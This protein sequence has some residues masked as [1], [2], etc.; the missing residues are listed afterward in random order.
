[1]NEEIVAERIELG[2]ILKLDKESLQNL[3]TQEIDEF[4]RLVECGSVTIPELSQH[5]DRQVL[6]ICT[7]VKT[8]G[9]EA[10]GEYDS[11]ITHPLPDM[12][13]CINFSP[14]DP[15]PGDLLVKS[16]DQL[17]FYYRL[18]GLPGFLPVLSVES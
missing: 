5:H 16:G 11:G 7:R 6:L 17:K 14:K 13:V 8:F 4:I 15:K 10:V 9:D 2:D 1:M 18:N 12:Q 3:S